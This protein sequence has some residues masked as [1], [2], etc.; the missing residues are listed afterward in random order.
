MSLYFYKLVM[1][2]SFILSL[3]FQLNVTDIIDLLKNTL[4]A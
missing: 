3:P 1:Q 2:N 4:V